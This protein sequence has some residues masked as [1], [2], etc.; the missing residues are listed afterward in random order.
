MKENQRKCCLSENFD[1]PLHH[2]IKRNNIMTTQETAKMTQTPYFIEYVCPVDAYGKQSFYYQLVRK[3]DLMILYANESYHNVIVECW[4][5]DI[6]KN[7]VTV[8]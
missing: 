7:E 3:S 6:S 1:I 4:R 8:W 2:Q 5:N